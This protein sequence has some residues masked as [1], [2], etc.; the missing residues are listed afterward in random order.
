MLVDGTIGF[1]P[2][3]VVAQAVEA[4]AAGYDGIWSAETSHDPF[5]PLVLA[6]EHTERLQV[7]TGIAVAFARNP[8][9]LA[10]TAND[11]QTAVRRTV[12]A[13]P[14]VPDQAP[15]REAL[16]DAVV[17]PRP[18]DARAD[19]GH[20]GHLG[21]AGPTAAGWPSGASTTATP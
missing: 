20:P 16:L 5:L 19:P 4:E 3:G 7:G 15:H 14:R 21:R 12:H 11:L 2:A 9:T 17:A 8:M 18:P 10:M 13:G 6:A 1:D